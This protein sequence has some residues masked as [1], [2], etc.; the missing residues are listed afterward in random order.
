MRSNS[1]FSSFFIDNLEITVIISKVPRYHNFY[2]LNGWGGANIGVVLLPLLG[3]SVLF[4]RFDENDLL[5]ISGWYNIFIVHRLC[6]I[7]I[8]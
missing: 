7:N 2:N 6:Q 5:P 3:Y 1:R 4:F 8:K